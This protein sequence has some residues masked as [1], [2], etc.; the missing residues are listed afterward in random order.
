MLEAAGEDAWLA[1]PGPQSTD[2]HGISRKEA[3]IRNLP[4][5]VAA[6]SPA[7]TVARGDSDLTVGSRRQLHPTLLG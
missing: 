4:V 5:A 6:H 1:C 7:M 2:A 3:S